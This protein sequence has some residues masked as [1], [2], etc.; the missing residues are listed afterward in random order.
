MREPAQAGHVRRSRIEYGDDPVLAGEA[1][2]P[3]DRIERTFKLAQQDTAAAKFRQ[4]GADRLRVEPGVCAGRYD[5]RVLSVLPDQDGRGTGGQRGF[6]HEIGRY[7]RAPQA[8]QQRDCKGICAHLPD[9]C[10]G[11]P[12]LRRGHRLIGPLAA[13]IAVQITAEDRLARLG[14]AL[15]PLYKIDVQAPEHDDSWT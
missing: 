15:D 12:E 13:R 3:L 1:E 8:R 5:N 9:H 6:P 7:S 2:R 10:H 11:L 4:T 14:K